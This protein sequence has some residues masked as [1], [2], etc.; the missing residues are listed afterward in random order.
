VTKRKPLTEGQWLGAV[1]PGELL[2]YLQ[3][4]QVITRVPGGRR[5]LALFSCACC[6]LVWHL[7]DNEASRRAVEVSELAAEGQASRRELEAAATAAA[8]VATA[9]ELRVIKAHRN[10]NASERWEV[11]VARSLAA[12]A[13]YAATRRFSTHSV[14]IPSGSTA[15]AVL[16][17]AHGGEAGGE[18]MRAMMARQAQLVRCIFSNPFRLLPEIDPAWLT[19]NSDAVRKLAASIHAERRFG[20]LPVLADALEEAGC[21]DETILGHCRDGGEHALG[22]WVLD[23]LLGKGEGLL[24]VK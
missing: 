16:W 18:A 5:R 20:D 6:R 1:E 13:Y 24:S 12:A 8:A 2:S 10:P 4:H 3:Q 21:S 23:L 19:W 17:L 22:C 15:A 9:V 14:G 7:F 11:G